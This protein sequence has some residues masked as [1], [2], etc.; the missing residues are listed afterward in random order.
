[1]LKS[2][3]H[4]QK[5]VLILFLV[6]FTGCI[7]DS[8]LSCPPP[9]PALSRE[10]VYAVVDGVE[11]T[12]DIYVPESPGVHPAVITVHGG[13]WRGGDKKDH[14]PIAEALTAQGYVVF[15]INYR[16]APA[17]P[18]PAAVED[19]QCAVI[20]VR[21]H[22]QA[23]GVDPGK[24]ALLG[25]SAGGHLAVLGGL[26]ASTRI[27]SSIPPAPWQPSCS[28]QGKDYRI[29]AVISCFG[30]LDLEFHG[31]ESP[32]TS[33]ILA[34]FLGDTCLQ[35]PSLCAA[36]NPMTYVSHV[37]P[38]M[39]LIHGTLDDVVGYEN[40]ERF[41]HAL[42]DAGGQVILLP[43]KAGHGFIIHASTEEAVYAL[44]AIYTFLEDVFSA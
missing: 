39:L 26:T 37:A 27:M 24:I 4:F 3:Y 12:C 14:A 5:W 9:H 21:E 32:G 23:Y 6:L 36:A 11:L 33:R 15:C 30:P 19:V 34:T 38:P 17:Y 43:V 16:L 28:S 1:M 2:M 35:A 18:F 20:W 13:A 44:E 42:S 41:Y 40:S 8:S 7:G 22:A 10:S 25:T 31:R 29:Q